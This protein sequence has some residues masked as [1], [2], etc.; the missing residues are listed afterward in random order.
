[1]WKVNYIT[2]KDNIFADALSR[3]DLARFATAQR[4]HDRTYNINPSRIHVPE[5]LRT[6]FPGANWTVFAQ[7]A[8]VG[9]D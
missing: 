5:V 9:S 1:M 8:N 7:T 4:H 2:T 6:L 3:G